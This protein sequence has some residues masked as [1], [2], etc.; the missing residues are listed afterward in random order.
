MKL[1]TIYLEYVGTFKFSRTVSE[2]E[3]NVQRSSK[4]YHLPFSSQKTFS[5]AVA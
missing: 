5:P 2:M 1:R 4:I 3:V